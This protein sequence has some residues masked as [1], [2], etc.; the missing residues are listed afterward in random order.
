[1]TCVLIN[2]VFGHRHTERKTMWGQRERHRQAKRHVKLKLG[3]RHG[4]GSSTELPDVTAL[5]PDPANCGSLL[6]RFTKS[7]NLVKCRSKCKPSPKIRTWGSTPPANLWQTYLSKTPCLC[8]PT[9]C[10]GI[11]ISLLNSLGP[12]DFSRRNPILCWET[13][14]WRK[15]STKTFGLQLLGVLPCC[16]LILNCSIPVKVPRNSRVLAVP[17]FSPVSVLF[18]SC[19]HLN[20]A[21]G[22]KTRALPGRDDAGPQPAVTGRQP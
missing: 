6:T 16:Q 15:P 18:N 13:K 22:L 10:L 1:M 2:R 21:P 7:Y 11:Q 9:S 19:S 8:F 3:D 17:N 5:S 4:P 14:Y 12:L 20:V